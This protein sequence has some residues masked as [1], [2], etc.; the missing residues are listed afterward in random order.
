ME[1]AGLKIL[2][3]A[4]SSSARARNT[5]SCAL[6]VLIAASPISIAIAMA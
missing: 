4:V 3:A 2:T 1:P 6:A 5:G